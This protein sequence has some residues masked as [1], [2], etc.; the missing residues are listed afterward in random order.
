MT[1]QLNARMPEIAKAQ[2]SAETSL[3][4][5]DRRDAEVSDKLKASFAA[6]EARLTEVGVKASAVDGMQSS[7]HT[8]VAKQEQDLI[9]AKAQIEKVVL[10]TVS[11][12]ERLAQQ[13][14]G[15]TAP[16]E[17]RAVGG[18][19]DGP[20]L[21]DARK[22]EVAELTDTMSKAASVLWRKN[23]DLHLE[24]FSDFGLG[25]KES[26]KKVRLH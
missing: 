17:Q 18:D 21:N 8:I 26:L 6:I 2:S 4:E 16:Q 23:L 22:N 5:L 13:Q 10:G 25:T 9:D 12:V 1:E 3:A 20:K 14:Q 19:R 7:I 24:E 15:D 11:H